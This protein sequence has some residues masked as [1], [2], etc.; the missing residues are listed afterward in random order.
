MSLERA[1]QLATDGRFPTGERVALL[2]LL[3]QMGQPSCVPR[4]LPLLAV[5]E[6]HDVEIAT[7]K[8]IAR[9]DDDHVPGKVLREYSRFSEKLKSLARQTLFSRKAWTSAFLRE[10]DAKKIDPKAVAVEELRGLDVF[11]DA[12]INALVNKHWGRVTRG[13]PEERLADIRRFN[14][15]LRA[16]PGDAKAGKAVFKEHCAKCHL[17][18]GEGEKIG[19]D[20]TAA[21]RKDRNYLL[22][23]TVDPSCFIRVEYLSVQV[24]TSD[25]RIFQGLITEETPSTITLV[26]SKAEAIKIRRAEIEESQPLQISQMPEDLMN[27][28]TPQ[29]RRDLFAYL[30][31]DGPAPQ[32]R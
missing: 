29:Q 24:L 17:L 28:L 10:V 23:S 6:Q 7:L 4:I 32:K 11:N 20:L 27:P 31:S 21:N 13:T 14:N 8:A 16:A 25:G 3:A 26:N 12:G 22:T 19:P 15:D 5:E 18:F 2:E 30:E 9:F 1:V